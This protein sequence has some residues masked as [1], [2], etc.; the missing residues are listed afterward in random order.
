M[1]QTK[2]FLSVFL[3]VLMIFS[4]VF[5]GNVFTVSATESEK[6]YYDSAGT[7]VFIKAV[8]LT[9]AAEEERGKSNLTSLGLTILDKD[10][11]DG[12]GG[13]KFIYLGWSTTTDP[14]EAITGLRVKMYESEP[15]SLGM[16]TDENGIEWYPANTGIHDWVPQ[17]HTDGCVDLNK[18]GGGRYIYLY[19][20]KDPAYGLPIRTVNWSDTGSTTDEQLTPVVDMDSPTA[21]RNINYGT[22]DGDKI[23]LFT[24]VTCALVDLDA[25][26]KAS[27]N[28]TLRVE[29]SELFLSLHGLEDYAYNAE[30]MLSAYDDYMVSSKYSQSTIDSTVASINDCLSKLQT[31]VYF[32]AATNGGVCD[33]EK[34]IV[35][36][37]SELVAT[38]TFSDSNTAGKDGY[39]FVGWSLEKNATTG[40]TD[41][42]TIGL[43]TT[44]YAIFKKDIT[45]TYK[46]CNGNV[47]TTETLSVYN[48]DTAADFTIKE[49]S[50]D[51]VTF[52]GWDADNDGK[53]DYAAGS[54]QSFDGDITLTATAECVVNFYDKDGEIVKTE[55]V[56]YGSDTTAPEVPEYIQ[57]NSTEHY[58]FTGWNK[59][60]TGIT[61]AT[62]ISAIYSAE[63]HTLTQYDAKAPDLGTIGWDAYE[64]CALCGYNT[65]IELPGLDEVSGKCGDNLTWV[66]T[67]DG[68]LTI[69]G[70]GEMYDY[71][72]TNY[73]PWWEYRESINELVIE[74]GITSISDYSFYWCEEIVEVIIP[75]SVTSIGDS[76]FDG[77]YKLSEVT[78]SKNLTEI[79]E[80]AFYL[81]DI[82]SVAIPEG[83]T[84]INYMTFGKC[85]YLETVTI[86]AS[87][88]FVDWEAFLNCNI[89]TVYYGGTE[90]QWNKITYIED[91]TE[92]SNATIEFALV[93]GTCGDNLTWVLNK[94]TCVLTIS[95]S[96][97]MYNYRTQSIPWESYNSYITYIVIEEGVTNIGGSAFFYCTNLVSIEIS[98]SVTEIDA[99]AFHNCKSLTSVTIPDSVIKIDNSAFYNCSSLTS[100]TIPDSVTSIGEYVFYNCTSLETVYY[101][102][103]I[104]QWNE[105]AIGNGGNYAFT[106]ANIVYA[107]PSGKCGDDAYWVLDE[108]TGTLTISG[109][110]A[111]Y[112]YEDSYGSTPWSAYA[113]AN[114]TRV[115]IEEGITDIGDN[116]FFY[117]LELISVTIPNSV[118]TIGEY[119]FGNCIQLTSAVIPDGVT[120]IE[121]G[122]F[123]CCEKLTELTIPA[124]V[125]SI[126]DS[127]FYSCSG[128]ETVYYGGTEE[129][130]NAIEINNYYNYNNDP[131]INVSHV[132]INKDVVEPTCVTVG[133]EAGE[134]CIKCAE[135]VSGGTEIPIRHSGGVATC[136]ALAICDVCG[137]AYG[138]IDENNHELVSYPEQQPTYE[139]DG[140]KAYSE[141]INCD[142]TTY[143]AIP[144]YDTGI[145]GDNATYTFD[146]VTGELRIS[147]TGEMYDYDPNGT[148][149]PWYS[150]RNSIT[151]L[152]IEDGITS[153]GDCAFMLCS[154]LISADLPNSLTSIGN[155]AF[156]WCESITEITLPDSVT[157]IGIK[158]FSVC[159]QLKTINIPSG[160]TVISEYAFSN[161]SLLEKVI[162]PASVTSI[163]KYA[164][165]S[166]THLDTVYYGGTEEQWKEIVIDNSSDANRYIVDVPHVIIS[167]DYFD[168]V[169]GSAGHEAGEYCIKCKEYVSGGA[170]IPATDVHDLVFYEGQ[171]PTIDQIGWV[172]YEACTK[173]DYSTYEEIPML[174]FGTCGDNLIWTYN[175]Y[176]R[177]LT[178][179]GTGDMTDYLAYTYTPWYLYR[180]YISSVVVEDGVTG[181]STYAFSNCENLT[182][183]TI[184][185]SVTSIGT[186]C[187]SSCSSLESIIL[188]D[189]LQGI[190][191]SIFSQCKKLQSIT[192]PASV[193]SINNYAFNECNALEIVYFGGTQEQWNAIEITNSSNNAII[194]VP[195]VIIKITG[196]PATCGNV[197]CEDSEYCIKCGEYV[198]GGAEIPATGNH[199]G[200]EA[201]CIAAAICD[202][203]G[204]AYGEVNA[205]NHKNIVTVTGTPATCG[206]DG[207]TDGEKCTDCGETLT[208]Q[209]VIAATGDHSGGEATCIAAAICDTCGNAYGEVNADNHKNT[210]TVTGTPATC[211]NT[212]LTDGEKCADCGE[213][214]TEQE[215]IAATGD[216]SGGEATCIAAAVCDTCGNAYG[217]ANADNHKN[218]ET[219]TGTPTTCGKDGLTDGKK[220]S[221]CGE[222]LTEQ[223]VILATGNHKELVIKNAAEATY[224]AEGYTGDKYCKECGTLIEKGTS[225]PKLEKPTEP[226]TPDETEDTNG[227]CDHLCH[228]DGFMGFIW[229]IVRFFWKLFKMN[230]VCEG[231]GAAHY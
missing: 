144:R 14:N 3:A 132:I 156:W 134:Y 163:E 159:Q 78:L 68:T 224:D 114:E 226:D 64:E 54:V 109:T 124:S 120:I 198:S 210:E 177:T 225:I 189:S 99:L 173:C 162:I 160:V 130:W 133:Y 65:Y 136:V 172:S 155:Y 219:V 85:E 72:S 75:D 29:N 194:N 214:L 86:P 67:I 147:G 146:R 13:S 161:S 106:N 168:P 190:G 141:C 182:N 103:S 131:I 39:T 229:K 200:G 231:C 176:T 42:M 115:I 11:N 20:T 165:Y 87:V 4:S 89:A 55:T 88:N 30:L 154:Y 187:F 33:I 31:Y 196:V 183:V 119:A 220:C 100:I 203:C 199:I 53:A 125:T 216:H 167:K 135:Y 217:E 34:D 186:G 209:E 137:D 152:Y 101:G 207:L 108:S 169:C 228:K 94:N 6:Y 9:Y 27:E 126:G 153:I 80:S 57:K 208:E 204:N 47:I 15:S 112:D 127:V 98:D 185:D 45:V 38:Y 97:E 184:A 82:K 118:K 90:A 223:E 63:A 128:L 25:L 51:G 46:D 56:P 102:G 35:D 191:R 175:T 24:K 8:A 71:D 151:S 178:I 77:C 188:P 16:I 37:G 44:V 28:A 73:A 164:F 91:N 222:M 201:T 107:I 140:W 76:A 52:L 129:Q 166:C 32:D 142:Y 157:T 116:A 18:G 192:I 36:I 148:D 206:K 230:P 48:N 92:L 213:T 1:K 180:R 143:V 7:P 70:E 43:M 61:S 93:E 62:A 145:C 202:T 5:V 171:E 121:A 117:C 40:V 10:L 139:Q 96:G 205:D 104:L 59:A 181:L 26:R 41:S 95:G 212:G 105:I 174:A 12:V 50:D 19:V 69:S 138:E 66:V 179:S 193:V 60:L 74:D 113:R 227:E 158:S 83:V 221:D 123:A 111:M 218:I 81:T 170:E 49:Y 17:L 215:V 110:G 197:G 22:E 21:C 58:K 122:T 150:E 79:G 23:Y 2:K 195:H 149:I 211:S 84:K